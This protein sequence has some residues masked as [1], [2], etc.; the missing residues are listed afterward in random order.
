[1]TRN[2]LL[3]VR[4]WPLCSTLLAVGLACAPALARSPDIVVEALL[5]NTVVLKVDGQRKTLRVGQSHGDITLL[6]ADQNAATLSVNGV[7]QTVG[8]SQHI[9]TNYNE[10]PEQRFTIP[11]DARNQ[12]NTTATINGRNVLVMVDTGASTVAI[13]GVQAQALGIDYYM[14]DPTPVE[15]ASGLTNGYAVM[16]RNV[17]VGGIEVNNVPA[18]VIEGNFPVTILLGMTYLRHVKMEE[19]NGILSLSRV[20]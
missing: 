8:M 6:A 12:Y 14:G 19:Q 20:Q 1:M 10:V 17:S 16:L 15:T 18:T 9:S 11:R 4:R 2:V 7:Q 3:T 5:P 13:S